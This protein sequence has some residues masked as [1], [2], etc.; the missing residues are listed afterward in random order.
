MCKCNSL[1]CTATICGSACHGPHSYSVYWGSEHN[2]FDSQRLVKREA[3]FLNPRGGGL[4]CSNQLWCIN[5]PRPEPAAMLHAGWISTQHHCLRGGVGDCEIFLQVFK[6]RVLDIFCQNWSKRLS[7]SSRAVFYRSVK[8]NWVFSEYLEMVH[9]TKYRNALCRLIVCS[10]QLRIE[11][12]R[13]ER[14]SVS[15][16]MRPCELCNTDVEDEFHFMLKCPVNSS[17]R[18]QLINGYYWL[19]EET[20]YV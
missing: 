6:Q 15:R 3:G 4:I 10:H 11:T 20:I 7:M 1:G 16:E 14:P 19:L 2:Q 17:I 13:C 8:E 12:G 5:I 9:V 18:K